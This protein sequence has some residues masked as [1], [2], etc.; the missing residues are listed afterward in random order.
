MKQSIPKKKWLAI[1]VVSVSLALLLAAWF[2]YRSSIEF[3]HLPAPSLEVDSVIQREIGKAVSSMP[4]RPSNSTI[5]VWIDDLPRS[6]DVDGPGLEVRSIYIGRADDK[7][8]GASNEWLVRISGD[9]EDVPAQLEI[10]LGDGRKVKL[11]ACP[12]LPVF[13]TWG[14]E[15]VSNVLS[16]R[17]WKHRVTEVLTTKA[18][19]SSKHR[20]S[21][22]VVDFNEMPVTLPLGKE[23][24]LIRPPVGPEK[25][26]LVCAEF[27]AGEIGVE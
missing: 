24:Y 14:P 13:G 11:E 21:V 15:V 18:E 22:D 10:D 9:L 7:Y 1:G 6:V 12:T 8:S 27:G 5:Y 3:L 26:T 4:A 16:N 25:G 17:W 19:T 20:V 2:V 23:A